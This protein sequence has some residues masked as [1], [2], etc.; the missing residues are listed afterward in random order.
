M[1]SFERARLEAYFAKIATQFAPTNQVTS[2]LVTHLLPER[3]GFVRAVAAM[4]RLRAVLP[5]PKSI[6]PAAQREVE[7][8]IPVDTLSR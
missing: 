5:K 6:T 2:F 8:T 4:S 3:P 1:E 7:Q